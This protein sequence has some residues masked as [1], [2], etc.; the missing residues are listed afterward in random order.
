M[1]QNLPPLSIKIQCNV[2]IIFSPLSISNQM[3][4]RGSSKYGPQVI[5][6]IELYG[7]A[8]RICYHY[9]CLGIGFKFAGNEIL[10]TCEKKFYQPRP[11]FSQA[12]CAVYEHYY[13][14]PQMLTLA[15]PRDLASVDQWDVTNYHCLEMCHAFLVVMYKMT[16]A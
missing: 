1:I 10:E 6:H 14:S 16:S 5:T 4:L 9:F 12:M 13:V 8:H 3:G 11:N 15:T 7:L 2:I